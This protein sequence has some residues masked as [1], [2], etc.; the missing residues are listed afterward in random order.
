M[1]SIGSLVAA[2][3]RTA[4]PDVV[5]SLACPTYSMLR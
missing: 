1:P 4:V 3:K 2:E 5:V